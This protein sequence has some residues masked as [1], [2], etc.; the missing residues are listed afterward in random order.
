MKQAPAGARRSLEDVIRLGPA[1]DVAGEV[2]LDEIS[3][4]LRKFS[5]RD[6]LSIPWSYWRFPE[7]VTSA[8]IACLYDSDGS[9]GQRRAHASEPGLQIKEIARKSRS[10]DS[11]IEKGTLSPDG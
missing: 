5:M 9:Q 11:E 3:E 4:H 10:G 2:I 8:K 6:L 1:L 7:G